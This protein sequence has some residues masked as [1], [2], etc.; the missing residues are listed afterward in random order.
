MLTHR[1]QTLEEVEKF[2]DPRSEDEMSEDEDR[3]GKLGKKFVSDAHFGGGVLS[4]PESSSGSRKDVIEQLIAESKKRKADRQKMKEETVDLTEKLDSE[5]RDLLPLV[6][7]KTSEEKGNISSS[8]GKREVDDYDI[9]VREMKFE[10]R[11]Q[12]TDK[13]KSEETI[14]EEE[15]KKIEEFE[16][17][18]ISR[19]Q[20]PDTS[21]GRRHKSAEDL[22]DGYFVREKIVDE[23]EELDESVPDENL[24]QQPMDTLNDGEDNSDSDEASESEEEDLGMDQEASDREESDLN[25]ETSD[26]EAAPSGDESSGDDDLMDLKQDESASEDEGETVACKKPILILTTSNRDTTLV[27]S[28]KTIKLVGKQSAATT[29]RDKFL[30]ELK[31]PETYE[32]FELLLGKHEADY[33]GKIVQQIIKI[34]DDKEYSTNLFIY[35]M[36]YT[37]DCMLD[38]ENIVRS[39][40]IFDR[41]VSHFFFTVV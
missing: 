6:N 17:E 20:V 26:R 38:C 41:Y 33:Q 7:F 29:T 31:V 28:E 32:E 12:A 8:S 40:Q 10:A 5:W 21:G 16:S 36:Q 37:D 30:S 23:S 24:E 25:E 34:K 19:M 14:R 15:Q 18:R 27:D 3:L 9:A 2:D 35:L 11:G 22:D 4:R 13:L 39:F 1:G